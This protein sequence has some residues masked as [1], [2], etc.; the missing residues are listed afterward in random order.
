MNPLVGSYPREDCLFLLKPISPRFLTIKEKERRIQSGI[1]HYSEMIH[2]ESAPSRAYVDLFLALTEHHKKRMAAEVMSLAM[3]IDRQIDG[4]ITILSLL[5]AGTP[6]GVLLHRTLSQVFNRISRHY[7]VSVIRDKGID[8][9]ALDYLWTQGCTP[10]G[11]VF[12]D[13]WTAKGVVNATLRQ[14]IG[15]YV[16]QR[17]IAL[18][19]GLFVLSDIGGVADTTACSEDYA[20]PSAILNSTVSGLVSRSV[21]NDDVGPKDFHGCVC[22]DHL[23]EHDYS[24][25][26][27]DT[28]FQEVTST[29]IASPVKVGQSERRRRMQAFLRKV[30]QTMGVSDLNRIKP[31][32]A[33]TTRVMLRRIPDMLL[34]RDE[35][36]TDVA[37]LVQLAKEKQVPIIVDDQ[38][39]FAACGLIR[40]LTH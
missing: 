19:S 35:R 32:V 34:L 27:V 1:A 9:V 30:T 6:I 22:Y 3:A 12:V 13:G 14:A 8:E 24:K 15:R 20:I 21:L 33:E 29:N 16:A 31:G 23:R 18:S 38:M 26:F 39:P 7:S 25:W 17:D 37:H 36:D 40:D 5:R 11:C 10:N 4:D 28:V 2:Q